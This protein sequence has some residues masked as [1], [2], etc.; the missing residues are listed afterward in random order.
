MLKSYLLNSLKYMSLQNNKSVDDM[1]NAAV[2][3]YVRK[4]NHPFADLH[5]DGYPEDPDDAFAFGFDCWNE[6]H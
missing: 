4:H 2:E 3:E 1:I 5:I 6:E